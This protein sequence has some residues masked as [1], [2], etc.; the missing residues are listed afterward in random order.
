MGGIYWL[1]SYPKS[2][3]TWFRAVLSNCLL[4]SKEPININDLQ[5]D[6]IASSRVWFDD[7][8]GFDSA[9]L[10]MR[11]IECL[12]PDVYRWMKS[13]FPDRI[14]YHKIH[15]AYSLGENGRPLV[16]DLGTLGAVYILRNPL[17]VAPSLAH[18][19]HVDL[20]TAINMMCD[21]NHCL[22]RSK[23]KLSNQLQQRLGSWS[24]HVESWVDATDLN[25]FVLR[26][27]DMQYEPSKSFGEAFS[28][29]DVSYVPDQLERAIA[30]SK[31]ENLVDQEKAN[32]FR[33]R[34]AKASHFFRKGK[35][36]EWRQVLS[37]DQITRL[38]SEHGNVMQRFG[39]L[40]DNGRPV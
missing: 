36:G 2:G 15:D 29:L 21:P 8:L 28:F 38:I 4:N 33:E 17:D 20:D 24:Q 3:N 27:E 40:D 16:D 5:T 13:E 7:V 34:P 11:E 25:V 39:Y 22:S 14:G 32:G 19:S 35:V 18:H 1:A 6:A 30:F 10:T 37:A 31:F 23:N 9:D 26:Y 12:R